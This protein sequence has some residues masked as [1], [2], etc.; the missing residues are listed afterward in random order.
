MS[1]GLA[2]SSEEHPPNELV[3]QAVRGGLHRWH[4]A[5]ER[6][7]LAK[8]NAAIEKAADTKEV[9]VSLAELLKKKGWWP[10]LTPQTPPPSAEPE[11]PPRA[12]GPTVAN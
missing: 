10:K 8:A 7:L 4:P 12:P 6:D 9:R 1:L 2:L 11:P 5:L 3:R